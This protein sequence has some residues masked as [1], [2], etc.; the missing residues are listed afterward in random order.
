MDYDF[1]WTYI[2]QS[3]LPLMHGLS[4]TLL[5][6]ALGIIL[7]IIIGLA[8]AFIRVFALRGANAV[9]AGY[10]ELIRNTPIL[11][12]LFFIFFGLPELGVQ[13]SPFWSGVLMLTLWGG[14]YNVES[15][16]G[17]VAAVDRGLGEAATALGLRRLQYFRF[18]AVPVAARLALPTVLN[19]A[20]S[21]LKNS[22]YLQT[23]GLA[24]LTFVAVDRVSLS[25]RTLE[26]FATI[27][28]IYL[29][30]GI[31]LS[32]AA[33]RVEYHLRQPFRA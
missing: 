13:L 33:G 2:W 23:I 1:D 14:A 4:V 18:V 25:Y 15:M 29:T 20:I 3:R 12:Q 17:A 9:V 8:G 26:M 6:S 19:T 7:A 32:A 28:A 16:R 24:E 22:A 21:M 5:V 30:L 31:A 27:G 10:V 11:A